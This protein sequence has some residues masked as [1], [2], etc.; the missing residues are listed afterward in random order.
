MTSIEAFTS[1]S[2]FHHHDLQHDTADPEDVDVFHVSVP[3]DSDEELLALVF[4]R[5]KW[6]VVFNEIIDEI[7]LGDLVDVVCYPVAEYALDH[8]LDVVKYVDSVAL[9][10]RQPG[11]VPFTINGKWTK[12]GSIPTMISRS[13]YF[14]EVY[15]TRELKA[16]TADLT[17]FIVVWNAINGLIE[18][19]PLITM[20]QLLDMWD[21]INYYGIPLD[22]PFIESYLSTVMI[23]IRNSKHSK[24]TVDDQGNTIIG[25]RYYPI[26]IDRILNAIPSSVI[27]RILM[28]NML[29]PISDRRYN[30]PLSTIDDW[31][32]KMMIPRV[33]T[34]I[35]NPAYRGWISVDTDD[36]KQG[37]VLLSHN[38][39]FFPG[40]HIVASS[41]YRF[42]SLTSHERKALM[43]GK[44]TD[45]IR[46]YREDG[47]WMTQNK[48][49]HKL[50]GETFIVSAPVILRKVI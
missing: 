34:K 44:G 9:T 12:H 33:P 31:C 28:A 15:E 36:A 6:Y 24:T 19:P 38:N 2:R 14:A 8:Y 17:V 41:V 46:Y 49:H 48:P 26:F 22:S 5:K 30:L 25:D 50:P 13:S 39:P 45:S 47:T 32:A 4:F 37:D 3:G 18:M 29:V 43:T 40:Q 21:V 16:P 11:T 10:V 20:D 35:Y 7:Q 42:I 23:N 1:L 27:D